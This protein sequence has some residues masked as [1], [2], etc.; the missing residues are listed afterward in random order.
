[1]TDVKELTPT[2]VN[3]LIRRIE[4]HSKEKQ[5]GRPHVKVGICFTAVGMISIPTETEILAMMEEIKNM[6]YAFRL[7]A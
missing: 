6:P 2:P 3:S 4:V 7:T 1:M 5:N